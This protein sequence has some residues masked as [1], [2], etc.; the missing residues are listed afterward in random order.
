MDG[1]D[2]RRCP[3]RVGPGIKRETDR[4]GVGRLAGE[5]C[6]YILHRGLRE[7]KA[8]RASR[9]ATSPFPRGRGELEAE[10]RRPVHCLVLP[11]NTCLYTPYR[12]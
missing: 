1:A 6:G 7:R 4:R 10:P 9:C 8:E 3:W 12:C 11:L 2:L 5:G